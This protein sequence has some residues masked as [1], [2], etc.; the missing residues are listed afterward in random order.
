[1]HSTIWER[2]H[3]RSI[4]RD[5]GE[6]THHTVREAKRQPTAA[7]GGRARLPGQRLRNYHSYHHGM[8]SSVVPADAHQACGHVTADCSGLVATGSREPPRT[9]NNDEP[10]ITERPLPRPHILMVRSHMHTVITALSAL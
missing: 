10:P 3:G 2:K 6:T 8:R 5:V 4:F 7:N 1:M 9:T